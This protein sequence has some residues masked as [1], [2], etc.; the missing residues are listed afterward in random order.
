MPAL[1]NGYQ[2]ALRAVRLRVVRQLHRAV[3]LRP[4]ALSNVLHIEPKMKQKKKTDTK[5]KPHFGL[6]NNRG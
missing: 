2:Q 4:C 1:T 5:Q 3:Q 6:K